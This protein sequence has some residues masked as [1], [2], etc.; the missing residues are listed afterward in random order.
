MH[1]DPTADLRRAYDRHADE[2]EQNNPEPWKLAL[3][4]AFLGLLQ[5]ERARTLLE[6]GAGPGKDSLFFQQQGLDV[7]AVDLS[8]AMVELCRQ[9]GL[10]ASAGDIREQD[11]PPSSFDAVYSLNCLLHV[12]KRELPA[13]LAAIQR[14]LRPGGLFFLGLWGG[15]DREGIWEGD[16]YE[17]KRFFSF[18]TDDGIR[19]AVCPF[20]DELAFQALPSRAASEDQHFQHLILRRPGRD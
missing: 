9:K 10:R 14:V 4:Q 6:V 17:P 16:Q 11:F 12:P 7:T 2:R 5:A 15:P 20:F 1:D 8:P 19:A 18:H 3:R 13:V